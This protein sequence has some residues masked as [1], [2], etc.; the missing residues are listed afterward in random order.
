MDAA[1]QIFVLDFM[2]FRVR[3][4]DTAGTITTVA[5]NGQGW[6][7]SLERPPI[8]GEGVPATSTPIT[9]VN[10]GVDGS[11]NLYLVDPYYHRVRRVPGVG[12]A[13][14]PPTTSSPA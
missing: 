8:S 6:D 14:P 4:I 9:A 13:G 12:S 3:R 10:I 1:D 7:F 11:G 5:G 2:N